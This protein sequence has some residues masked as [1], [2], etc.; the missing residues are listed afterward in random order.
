MTG[1]IS[2]DPVYAITLHQ[3]RASL[4]ALGMKKVETRSWP[5]PARTW[6]VNRAKPSNRSCGPTGVMAG[7]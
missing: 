3:P 7:D 6:I 5:A 1:P 2:V 4:I